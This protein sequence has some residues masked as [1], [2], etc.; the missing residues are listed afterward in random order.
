[1]KRQ[2]LALFVLALLCAPALAQEAKPLRIVCFGDSITGNRPREAYLDKYMKW[3]DLLGM[4]VEAR[5]GAKVESLNRG[6]AGDATYAKPGQSMPGAVGRYK[7]D[8]IDE[9][10]D[11]AVI[12]I[13]GNDKKST[14]EEQAATRANLEKIVGDTKAAGIKV[15][16]LQYAVLGPQK[17]STPLPNNQD[18]A[19]PD[20]TWYHLAGNNP[21]IAEVAKK[22]DVPT[23][24]LQPAFDEAAKTQSREALVNKV[25]GVHLGPYGEITTARAIF[26]K[27]VELQWVK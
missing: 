4:L 8:I 27:L 10:P 12:L 20:K 2:L 9:K 26:T 21:L 14:P 15:L 6:W 18:P 23:V 19:T 22:F 5:T 13:S 7:A 3:S 17:N 24:A 16:L 11:I 1:M 25:D